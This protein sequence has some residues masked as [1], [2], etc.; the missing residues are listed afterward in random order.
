MSANTIL[1]PDKISFDWLILNLLGHDFYHDYNNIVTRVDAIEQDVII[2]LD[3]LIDNYHT[4]KQA[5]DNPD[6]LL[7]ALESEKGQPY[8]IMLGGG[9]KDSNKGSSPSDAE[10]KKNSGPAEDDELTVEDYEDK[11]IDSQKAISKKV[12]MM[13]DGV[14]K[15]EVGE[16]EDNDTTERYRSS[17]IKNVNYESQVLSLKM[18]HLLSKVKYCILQIQNGQDINSIPMKSTPDSI[19]EGDHKEDEKVLEKI[20]YKTITKQQYAQFLSQNWL[21]LVEISP[22]PYFDLVSP[23]HEEDYDFPTY[24]R[25]ISYT[26]GQILKRITEIKE[27]VVDKVGLLSLAPIFKVVIETS[28]IYEKPKSS[29]GDAEKNAVNIMLKKQINDILNIDSANSPYSK[30]KQGTIDIFHNTYGSINN[31]YISQYLQAI[32]GES[33]VNVANLNQQ[34][35][36]AHDKT[37]IYIDTLIAGKARPGR[38]SQSREEIKKELNELIP[39]RLR[40]LQTSGAPAYR[41]RLK[42]TKYAEFMKLLNDSKRGLPQEINEESTLE[43]LKTF[44]KFV[45]KLYHPDKGNSK[46]TSNYFYGEDIKKSRGK[47]A[48]LRA[49]LMNLFEPGNSK[50]TLGQILPKPDKELGKQIW[51]SFGGPKGLR[52]KLNIL[53]TGKYLSGGGFLRE[54]GEIERQRNVLQHLND[55]LIRSLLIVILKKT[56]SI[57]TRQV[58]ANFPIFPIQLSDNTSK[59]EDYIY[60]RPNFVS[61]FPEEVPLTTEWR[62]TN[63]IIGAETAGIRSPIGTNGAIFWRRIY[64]SIEPPLEIPL[65]LVERKRIA[66]ILFLNVERLVLYYQLVARSFSIADNND[67]SSI[68]K[69][70]LLQALGFIVDTSKQSYPT[71]VTRGFSTIGFLNASADKSVET[72]ASRAKVLKGKTDNTFRPVSNATFGTIEEMKGKCILERQ[73]YFGWLFGDNLTRLDDLEAKLNKD[74]LDPKQRKKINRDIKDFLGEPPEWFKVSTPDEQI[75]LAYN[76]IVRKLLPEYILT[77]GTQRKELYK[78]LTSDVDFPRPVECENIECSQEKPIGKETESPTIKSAYIINNASQIYA[79]LD[80]IHQDRWKFYNLDGMQVRYAQYCPVSSIA[81]SMPLCALPTKGN[82]ETQ[83]RLVFNPM[84]ITVTYN[85]AGDDE[86]GLKD[87]YK[88]TMIPNEYYNL[89][90]FD[91]RTNYTKKGSL[92]KF[93][94][95]IYKQFGGTN[96]KRKAAYV[97]YMKI[98]EDI[99]SVKPIDSDNIDDGDKKITFGSKIIFKNFINEIKLS[100]QQD[101]ERF[102]K[103]QFNASI[104]ANGE[105]LCEC[106]PS[107]TPKSLEGAGPFQAASTYL[108]ILKETNN[109]ILGLKTDGEKVEAES[110]PTIGLF[111]IFQENIKKILNMTVRKSM[112]DYSQELATIGKF[113]ATPTNDNTAKAQ[114]DI[115]NTHIITNEKVEKVHPIS[116]PYDED[117]DSLRLFVANDRPSAYRGIFFITQALDNSFNSKSMGGYYRSKIVSL[118]KGKGSIDS[119][120]K[121]KSFIVKAPMII[122]SQLPEYYSEKF[123]DSNSRESRKNAQNELRTNENGKNIYGYNKDDYMRW[124]EQQYK[125]YDNLVEDGLDGWKVASEAEAG[126]NDDAAALNFGGLVMHNN[127]SNNSN[128]SNS[129]SSNSNNNNNNDEEGNNN[130]VTIVQ[131]KKVLSERNYKMIFGGNRRHT[132]KNFKR[133]SRNKTQKN[134]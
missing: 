129:N 49:W 41:T 88:F 124:K 107:F 90:D 97:S 59:I 78:Y 109:I 46:K 102:F 85:G 65:K 84:D 122:P 28:L 70:Y 58:D 112:G 9:A 98:P 68:N 114:Y 34:L 15:E 8:S 5:N 76:E 16:K 12:V 125:L 118:G 21:P 89:V 6:D 115:A 19:M 33:K 26:E 73:K 25:I 31:A 123:S 96:A 94:S 63:L 101:R 82:T 111:V 23:E 32:F 13:V 86:K 10:Q 66:R 105:S 44:E 117:G 67:S 99:R 47:G 20:I 40:E 92:L 80:K 55:I 133:I 30:N 11:L 79:T 108:S 17:I 132:R 113:G 71:C 7:K 104:V 64:G 130:A 1:L 75:Q 14:K 126:A 2:E 24:G 54:I 61:I 22:L 134:I 91:T 60:N 72:K 127:S 131:G 83:K 128:S 29:L 116:L 87:Y 95:D 69:K 3:L 106:N 56:D 103:V 57:E 121:G 120:I 38:E 39:I 74:D 52:S 81:D 18:Q 53:S 42:K 36:T 4:L 37:L 27:S 100:M 93:L 51:D 77:A 50:L 35:V 45:L 119:E 48:P 62:K 110:H 43:D